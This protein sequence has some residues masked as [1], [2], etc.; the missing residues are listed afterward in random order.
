MWG[1]DWPV[2]QLEASYDDW[3]GAAEALTAGLSEPDRAAIFGGTARA[4]YRI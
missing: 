1:S 3:R 2:C 4:F